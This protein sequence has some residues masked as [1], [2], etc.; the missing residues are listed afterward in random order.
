MMM[1]SNLPTGLLHTHDYSLAHTRGLVASVLLEHV[2]TP[3]GQA[4]L[5][6][7]DIALLAGLEWEA[8]HATLKSLM[9]MGAI[10]IDRHRLALNRNVLHE[11]LESWEP[12]EPVL[13]K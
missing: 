13:T 3:A 12:E 11:I 8:V 1:F 5:S 9:D 10:K 7:R 4:R 6:Q 2:S